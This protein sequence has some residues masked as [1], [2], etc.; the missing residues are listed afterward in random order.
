M[1]NKLYRKSQVW[2]AVLFILAYVIGNS[3]LIELSINSGLEMVYTIPYNLVLLGI[4]FTFIRK[5]QLSSYYGLNK[6]ESKAKDL[7]YYI[8]LVIIATVNIWLGICFKMNLTSTI[9]YFFAMMITSVVEEILFRGLLFKGIS[10]NSVKEAIII[11]SITFGIGHIINLF[12][13]NSAN[14]L[15]TIC[16]LFYAVAIGF[17]LASVLCVGKSIIPCMITHSMLNALSAFSNEA[18]LDPILVPVSIV[19]CIVSFISAIWIFK[20]GERN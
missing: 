10:E 20:K 9:I 16:Q 15:E 14:Y 7:L 8:P 12:N 17:L 18:L 11:T 13:G 1:L 3:Y 19:L 4:I 6:V 2:F 5:N